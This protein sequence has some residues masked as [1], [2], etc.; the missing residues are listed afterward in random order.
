[1][2]VPSA[3]HATERYDRMI[4]EWVAAH[5]L[6]RSDRT[7]CAHGL[8]LRLHSARADAEHA[9]R[10]TPDLLG[11]APTLWET[12]G[13][14]VVLLGQAWT[15]ANP[16]D[17]RRRA[18]AERV[19]AYAARFRLAAWLGTPGDP[20]DLWGRGSSPLLL[21]RPGDADRFMPADG[22]LR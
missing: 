10:C 16:A 4:T 13:R 18:V 15:F 6:T 14:P 22:R 17:A 5:D 9:E 1:V 19:G 7:R 2:I 3:K 12:D 20:L 11:P 8:L 21:C